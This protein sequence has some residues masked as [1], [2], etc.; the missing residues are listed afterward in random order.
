MISVTDLLEHAIDYGLTVY[1]NYSKSNPSF[2][3]SGV[4]LRFLNNKRTVS[5]RIETYVP[6]KRYEDQLP[7]IIEY[8][9]FSVSHIQN[10]CVEYSN[11]Y[12]EFSAPVDILPFNISTPEEHVI[13]I[14]DF[15]EE[16]F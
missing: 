10:L 2:L 11:D 9:N 7:T 3:R 13:D 14:F 12:L 15:E 8:K 1:F 5:V 4:P 6:Y 16:I